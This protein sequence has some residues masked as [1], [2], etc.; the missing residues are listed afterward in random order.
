MGPESDLDLVN[1]YREKYIAFLDL[2]G[3]GDLLDR[4][5]QD[6]LER[7]RVVEA[8]KLVRDTIGQNPA[9]DLRFTYFSDC[10]VLSAERTAHALWEIF[11]SI[12][13]LSFNLLQ[14][15]LLV[16]GGLSAGLMHH[17]KDFVFGTALTD[18]YHLE[19]D[20]A[21]NPL[22][23]LSAEVVQDAAKLGPDFTQWITEDG[24]GR[25]FV[26]YLIRYA[27]YTRERQAGKLIL[28]YPANRVAYF[29]SR[30]LNNDKDSVLRKAQ[31]FQTYWNDAV[32]ARGVL[33][34][35]EAGVGM[36][37]PEDGPT[38]IRRRLVAPVA[39]S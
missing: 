30:R 26:N 18:A 12:E 7:H 38:I 31:W 5:G 19:R 10:I 39:R 24:V 32:A 2:L 28:E 3:F 22:V 8:L 11:Q 1:N 35:I 34:R 9:I 29:I 17:S 13:L 14:Y 33:P 6:V 37:N 25:Y 21:K 27:A 20:K 15:D 23:L 36:T 16:R 4:I